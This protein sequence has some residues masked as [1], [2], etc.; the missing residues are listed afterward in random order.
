VISPVMDF[1]MLTHAS[2][3]GGGTGFRIMQQ[4]SW[5]VFVIVHVLP[6]LP[7]VPRVRVYPWSPSAF[8]SFSEVLRN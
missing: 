5:N 3:R 4:V 7:S 6:S 1:D 2:A 8:M